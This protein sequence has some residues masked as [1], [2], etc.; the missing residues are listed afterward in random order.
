RIGSYQKLRKYDLGL[1]P[2]LALE[3]TQV[4]R[5]QRG[6]FQLGISI[7]KRKQIP[8]DQS[9]DPDYIIVE[10]EKAYIIT[11]GIACLA[12]RQTFYKYLYEAYP[13]SDI[14]VS[15]PKL[16]ILDTYFN[17]GNDTQCDSISMINHASIYET[18]LNAVFKYPH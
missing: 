11:A 3:E 10:P 7:H 5:S 17:Q 15:L 13:N 6:R 8:I 4:T 2:G 1:L 12:R 14:I 18:E 9:I 16:E